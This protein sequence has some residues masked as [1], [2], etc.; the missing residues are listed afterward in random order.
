MS[1]VDQKKSLG[2]SDEAVAKRAYQIWEEQGRPEGDGSDNWQ[3][4][5]KQLLAE[6]RRRQPPILRLLNRLRLRAAM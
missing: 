5:Q 2:I 6:A 4:A 1:P 3:M